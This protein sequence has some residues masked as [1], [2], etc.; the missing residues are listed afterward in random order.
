M[1]IPRDPTSPPQSKIP[2]NV[3]I[4]GWVSLFNDAASEML[5]PIMPLFITVTLGASPALLG[6]IDGTAEGIGSALRWVGGALSDRFGRR[7]PFV[8]A[9]YAC[10]AL[11]KPVMGLAAFAIGWPLFM[12]GRC[13]DRFGKSIRN[14]ARDALIAASTDPASRG[15]AFGYQR[16]MDTCGAVAGPLIALGVIIALAGRHLTF[17]GAGES[18]KNLPLKWLFFLALAPG[19][20]AVLCA[21]IVQEIRPKPGEKTKTGGKP[22]PIFQSFPRP[23]WQ[24]IAAVAVFSLGNSSDT[25]LILRSTQIGLTFGWVILA[26]VMYNIVYAA[27]SEPMGRLSDK[28][29]R[30]PLLIA[31]WLVYAGVYAGFA[32]AR[33][34]WTPWVLLAIYGFYQAMTDGVTG[35]LISDVVPDS[36]RAGAIGLYY[37]AAGLAQLTASVI[38]GLVYSVLLFHG[39]VMLTFALGA[40]FALA[41]I[42]LLIVVR[43]GNKEQ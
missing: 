6:L 12:I 18:L 8:I 34:A 14:A 28:I 3:R 27:A 9:G 20:L 1:T 24:T 32:V 21:S 19:L 42:P 15:R 39:R 5:Y 16:A 10:S 36:K 37:T 13:F 43:T 41:A 17:S 30:K 29:G 33:G 7:K 35:A 2:R 4:L 22:P 25:F 11:S 26:Y 38:A 40:F 31:G 23:L